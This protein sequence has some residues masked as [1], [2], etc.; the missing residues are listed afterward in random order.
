LPKFAPCIK[1]AAVWCAGVSWPA[2]GFI[3]GGLVG[4][5]ATVCA[6]AEMEKAAKKPMNK[7]RRFIV[8]VEGDKFKVR[9]LKFKV[10]G[11]E[12]VAGRATK[13]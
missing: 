13:S 4:V 6:E 11:S 3:A 5:N 2:S 10:L 7:A 1:W 12:V 8:R 9:S